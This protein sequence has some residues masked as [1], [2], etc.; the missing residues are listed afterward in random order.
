MSRASLGRKLRLSRRRKGV[1]PGARR[2]RALRQPAAR[3]M[4]AKSRYSQPTR[5]HGQPNEV[6]Y[7]TMRGK[8]IIFSL[9]T[10]LSNAV[11][12]GDIFRCIAANGDVMF[13][14]MACPA[15]SQ[16]QHV[17]SYEPVPD[18]PTRTYD[19]AANA[20]ATSALEAREAAQQ[21]RAAAYQAQVAYEQAQAK[22]QSEQSSDVTEYSAGL[23]PFY[24]Q[25][26][27]RFHGH[28]HHPRQSM[29]AQSASHPPHAHSTAYTLHR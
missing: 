2:A 4:T 17:A 21:A 3:D 1:A 25:F 6:R 5:S 26:G 29:V 27:L 10:A 19:G 28:H 23:I 24:P 9:A 8:I 18:A 7:S 16:V 15:N 22:A 12:A 20:A 14:N 11:Y 13:T